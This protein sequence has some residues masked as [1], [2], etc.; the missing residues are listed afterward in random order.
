MKVI[1]KR[2]YACGLSIHVKV[3]TDHSGI[4]RVSLGHSPVKGEL[5][6]EIFGSAKQGALEEKIFAWMES[7]AHKRKPKVNLPLKVPAAGP[8]AN[9]ALE[10][11]R[12]IPF[13]KQLSYRHI[14]EQAGSPRAARA[15]GNVCH[16]NAFPLFI[17]CHRVVK[18]DGSLGGFAVDIELKKLLLEFE[19]TT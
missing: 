6:C 5:I 16:D 11:I 7:Y 12:H 13:G 14:A 19:K 1:S 17:P 3:F 10:T 8:F 4:E 15:V 9:S 2:G 18:S